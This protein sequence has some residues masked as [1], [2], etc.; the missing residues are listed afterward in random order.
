M[1]RQ[2]LAA[3]KDE[4]FTHW[5]SEYLA[6]KRHIG[7]PI[8]QRELAISLLDFCGITVGQK[9]LK[10]TYKRIR[11]NLNDYIRTSVYVCN[12]S[13]VLLTD[14]DKNS[15]F[16]HCAAWQ[17]PKG[18][19]GYSI[20]VDENGERLPRELV[21]KCPYP[22]VYYFYRK[23]RVPKHRYDPAHAGD[24]DY[25]QPAPEQDPEAE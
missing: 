10:S 25:V 24:Q 13:I 12:P 21:R 14:S 1:L 20:A 17:H 11:D 4:Q 22:Q 23:S 9:T 19:D 18:S 3:S 5:I 15:G 8:A 2:A 7:I 6:D 16:R